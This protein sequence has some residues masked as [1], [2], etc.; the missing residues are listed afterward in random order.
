MDSGQK[1]QDEDARFW[2]LEARRWR[3]GKA[4]TRELGCGGR[5]ATLRS[6]RLPLPGT[7]GPHF[8]RAKGRMLKS[9]L[10]EAQDATR[11]VARAPMNP[12]AGRSSARN[13]HFCTLTMPPALPAP[14]GHGSIFSECLSER[15]L[16]ED[17]IPS[18]QAIFVCC[19]HR[20]DE[21]GQRSVDSRTH[22]RLK[23]LRL[24]GG[25][26]KPYALRG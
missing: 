13:V 18:R 20:G 17:G 11:G 19:A 5:A 12:R 25:I 3:L 2:K 15:A 10:N 23:S 21:Y 14:S 16:H 6:P 24:P 7:W 4:K 9:N 1:I 8:A 22:E 26:V